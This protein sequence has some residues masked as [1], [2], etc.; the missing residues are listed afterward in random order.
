LPGERAEELLGFAGGVGNAVVG[1][2]VT[3]GIARL[4]DAVDAAADLLGDTG[5]LQPAN[6]AY[7]AASPPNPASHRAGR[8]VSSLAADRSV[9]FAKMPSRFTSISLPGSEAAPEATICRPESASA[10]PTSIGIG[11]VDKVTYFSSATS[12]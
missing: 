3:G 5:G 10:L 11:L 9:T 8:I 2:P 12:K 6:A 7:A 1:R 4:E